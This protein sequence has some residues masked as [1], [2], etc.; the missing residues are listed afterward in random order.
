S[1]TGD[2][3]GAWTLYKMP[4]QNDGTEGTPDHGCS[5]GDGTHGP[6]FQDYPHI[7]AD[8]NGVYVSTNEYD[9][10]GSGFNAAQIFAFSKKELAAHG[11]TVRM[12]MV[13]NTSVGGTPGFTVW[14]ATSPKGEY[15]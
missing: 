3:T 6:C 8:R 2:P 14:P 7:G 13:Q 11:P 10:F 5:N 1:N 4:V 12:T 9:T 15:A